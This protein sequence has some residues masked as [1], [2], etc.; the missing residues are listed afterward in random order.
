V[1]PPGTSRSAAEE[2][3]ASIAAF[4]QACMRSDRRSVYEGLGAPDTEALAQEFA[5]GTASL[6]AEGLAGAARFAAGAG[7]HGA[8]E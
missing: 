5:K 4:P 6:Q 8:A 2:I 3:A 7:R 1:V